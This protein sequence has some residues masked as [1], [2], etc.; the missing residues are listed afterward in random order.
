MEREIE[1]VAE[2]IAEVAGL[3]GCR[4]GVC[5]IWIRNTAVRY[6][7]VDSLEILGSE[8][9]LEGFVDAPNLFS[10]NLGHCEDLG[11][12]ARDL[13]LPAGD[14]DAPGNDNILRF[15]LECLCVIDDFEQILCGVGYILLDV[16]TIAECT[17][18]LVGCEQCLVCLLT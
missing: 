16:K 12:S 10:G 7:T 14:E 2:T 4:G 6:D 13:A 17:D 18:F 1:E 3:G 11:E 5:V 9:L 15:S 8:E